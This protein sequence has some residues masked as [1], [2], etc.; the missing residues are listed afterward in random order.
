MIELAPHHKRGLALAAPWL[1]SAGTLGFGAEYRNLIELRRLGAFVTNPLTWRRRTPAAPPNAAEVPGGLIIHTGLPNPGVP[2]ALRRYAREWGRLGAPV[3]VHLAATT[4]DEVRRSVDL[5]ERRDEVAALEI[6]LRDDLDA[7][8][9]RALIRAGRQGLPLI[10][11]LPLARADAL[12]GTAVEA[13]ADA[14]TVAA[15]PRVTM[16]V[17]GQPMTGRLYGPDQFPAALAA[18]KLV[19]AMCGGLPLIGAGGIYSADSAQEMLAA[20]ATAIQFDAVLWRDPG[21]VSRLA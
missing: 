3:I 8:E 1:N 16:D 17:A 5:L 2:S 18:V 20:G 21:L 9:L 4:P 10:V 15:P 7:D 13:G 14:L 19:R 6:G 11:R 12:C